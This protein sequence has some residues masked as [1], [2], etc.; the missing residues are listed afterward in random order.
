MDTTTQWVVSRIIL[1]VDCSQEKIEFKSGILSKSKNWL[2]RFQIKM[3]K[4]VEFQAEDIKRFNN[5]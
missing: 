5:L 1:E 3:H 4:T 2:L